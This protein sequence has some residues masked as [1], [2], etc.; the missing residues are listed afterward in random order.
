[1]KDFGRWFQDQSLSLANP[2]EPVP[3]ALP[4]LPEGVFD[5]GGKYFA[6][7]RSCE[8][9]YELGYDA[10]EFDGDTNYCGGSPRCL[11]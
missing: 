1:M 4:M 7:C 8:R 3:A 10:E 9:D 2:V 5:R 11:P 6:T